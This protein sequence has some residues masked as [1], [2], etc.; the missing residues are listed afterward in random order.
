[1]EGARAVVPSRLRLWRSQSLRYVRR[2]LSRYTPSTPR[3][4]FASSMS[5]GAL[6]LQTNRAVTLVAEVAKCSQASRAVGAY[7][8][9]NSRVRLPMKPTFGVSLFSA[10]VLLAGSAAHAQSPSGTYAAQKEGDFVVRNFSFQNGQSLPDVKLHYT[11]LGVPH[12]NA[13]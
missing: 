2:A 12:R 8:R 4:N 1:V 5:R 3:S 7:S 13:Q 10:F 6:A 9:E 11:T